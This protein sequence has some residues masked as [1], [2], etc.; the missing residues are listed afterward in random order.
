MKIA[1]YHEIPDA[2]Y[3]RDGL[4]AAIELLKREHE[5]VEFG[6][7][8]MT[9]VETG[10]FGSQMD[11]VR[12]LPGKKIWFH[13]GGPPAD[14]GFDYVVVLADQIQRWFAE[15]GIRSTVING[16]NTGLF[17]P[18]NCE[19]KYD[20]IF[21]AA[22]ARW[23]RHHLLLDWVK[24][25]GIDPKKVLVIGHK[26]HVETE[27][28]EMCEA[29]GFEVRDKVFPEELALLYNQAKECWIPS[30]TVGGSEKTLL[31]AKACGLKVR[32]AP[33]NERLVEMNQQPVRSHH[34]YAERIKDLL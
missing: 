30:E 27:C 17:K 20:V 12:K 25:A 1:L 33:D 32:V 18:V 9:L 34:Y 31:E 24:D 4:W 28:Y 7:G 8:D 15:S 5:I 19:K 2:R 26:Q 29:A 6:E 16:T 3:W 23:K 13:A 21:P 11:V 10:T 22:F 14:Y